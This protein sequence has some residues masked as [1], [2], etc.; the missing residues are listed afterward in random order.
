MKKETL[1]E[2]KTNAC[3]NLKNI[4]IILISVWHFITDTF[5]YLSQTNVDK[6][7]K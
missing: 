7:L 5:A 3:D 2:K 4:F 1:K 6:R